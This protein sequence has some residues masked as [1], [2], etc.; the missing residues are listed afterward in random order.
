MVRSLDEIQAR[1]LECYWAL[2]DTPDEQHTKILAI[3]AAKKELE[4][5][6]GKCNEPTTWSKQS[7]SEES[8]F[9]Q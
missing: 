2:A 9:E 3:S 5:V 1:L 8:E 7:E 4:W 6:L